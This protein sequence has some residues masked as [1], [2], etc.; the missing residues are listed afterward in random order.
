VQP[1]LL[2]DGEPA[3]ESESD[4]GKFVVECDLRVLPAF[5]V[6][7]VLEAALLVVAFQGLHVQYLRLIQ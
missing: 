1:P 7:S 2:Q 4:L 6:D 5:V 3:N